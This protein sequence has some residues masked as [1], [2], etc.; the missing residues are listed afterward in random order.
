M[1]IFFFVFI[2]S[3]FYFLVSVLDLSKL[4]QVTASN[5]SSDYGSPTV[6]ADSLVGRQANG[7]GFN[8]GGYLPQY[9]QLELPCEYHIY[10]VCLQVRQSSAGMTAHQLFVGQQSN[11][12][13]YTQ[14]F[15]GGTSDGQ[16]LNATFDPPLH[17]VRFLHI[18]T[19]R[20][21]SQVTW[22]KFL[23]YGNWYGIHIIR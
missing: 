12:L 20:N 19:R 1:I 13:K 9:V 15:I 5:F 4:A 17:D 8:S 16:W 2:V 6:Q 10:N 14:Y 22:L 11:N 21:P 23:V 3:S 7:L 18:L